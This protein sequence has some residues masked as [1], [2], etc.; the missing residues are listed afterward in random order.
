MSYDA[1]GPVAFYIPFGIANLPS[2]VMMLP[3]E[4]KR[5][6]VV[7]KPPIFPMLSLFHFETIK[8][9]AIA[10]TSNTGDFSAPPVILEED[11]KVQFLLRY[12][13]YLV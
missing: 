8:R 10:M 11:D 9:I 1:S 7:D 12:R 13:R 5:I 3:T 4:T 2:R 6:S